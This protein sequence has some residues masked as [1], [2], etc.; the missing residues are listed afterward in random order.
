MATLAGCGIIYEYLMAH[1]AGRVLGALESTIYA[2]IGIMIVAMGLGALLAKWLRCPFKSFA[3]LEWTIAFVGATALIV[4]SLCISLAF[5]FPTYLQEIYGLHPSITTN[6]D[7][8]KALATTAKATPFVVGALLGL[9]IGMEIPLIA[10]IRE[11]IHGQHLEHNLGTIYGADYI[12]AGIGAAIWV[13][14]CL[15]L[16]ILVAALSTALVNAIIGIAFLIKYQR[17]LPRRRALWLA[18]GGLLV[19]L[20][21]LAGG[22]ATWMENMHRALFK[23]HVL[24]TKVTPFQHLTITERVLGAG[25]PKITSLYINGRLQFSSNDELIYHSYLTHPPLLASARQ[26][27]ILVIGGGDGLA[28]RDILR[29]QPVAVTLIDLDGAMVSLFS[30]S[31]SEAPTAITERLLALNASAFQ[32]PR[33]DVII[34]DAFV[35]VESLVSA[36][37]HFDTIIV[38]LPDPSHPD[39]NKVYSTFFYL[40]LK[41]LLSGDGA[42][43]IQSTSPFHTKQAFLSIG[44]TLHA[45]GFTTEQYH[46]NVPTFGEWGWTIGTLRG[47][48]PS[49][50]IADAPTMAIT[51]P[52]S[53]LSTPQILAAFVFSSRYFDELEKININTLGSHQLYQYHQRAW[54]QHDGAFFPDKNPFD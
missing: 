25:L 18:H 53:W 39:I 13:L 35:E 3:W 43:G 27:Q 11:Q 19:L 51:P 49:A 38:D 52:A 45:A 4:I 33:V 9:M 54:K 6:G 26:E 46:A 20:A 22:G 23:D 10:R 14:F 32:D 50:R 17:Y 15:Q 8:V 16:P 30:G 41:Q 28:L 48:G 5:T 34:G 1:Y 2:M 7:V 44:K 37:R 31:D 47:E 21:V 29:W 12:G 40:R 36:G 24:Y 42:I